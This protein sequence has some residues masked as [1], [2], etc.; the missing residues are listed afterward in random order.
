[1]STLARLTICAAL[2]L[3]LGAAR[4][5]DI[6]A[7]NNVVDVFALKGDPETISTPVISASHTNNP[8][9]TKAAC[10]EASVEDTPNLSAF[11]TKRY[12]IV[13]GED[14]KLVSRCELAGNPA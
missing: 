6:G 1:M 13:E 3:S 14:F 9:A 8:F 2:A 7:Y 11:L 4:A 12:G 10:E 5:D